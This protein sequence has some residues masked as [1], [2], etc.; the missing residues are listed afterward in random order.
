MDFTQMSLRGNE[1]TVAISGCKKLLRFLDYARN[2][3]RGKMN[4][5][6]IGIATPMARKDIEGNNDYTFMSLRGAITTKQSLLK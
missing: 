6:F 1:M 5:S 4:G 2:D 3:R